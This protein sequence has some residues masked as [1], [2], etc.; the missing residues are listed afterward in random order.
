MG[1]KFGTLVSCAEPQ[2]WARALERFWNE[3]PKILPPKI[4]E[5]K[6]IYGMAQF[7]EAYLEILGLDERK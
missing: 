6:V 3:G 4:E 2:A 1:G 7:C 5:I